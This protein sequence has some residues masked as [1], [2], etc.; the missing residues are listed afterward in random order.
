MAN[1]YVT[2][3]QQHTHR[4][5]NQTLDCNCVVRFQADTPAEGRKKAFEFFG[6]KFFT[7]YHDQQWKE[8]EMLSYFPRGY[9]DL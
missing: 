4:I 7:D 2:L 9:V 8:S 6:D 3:G 5:N 1:H